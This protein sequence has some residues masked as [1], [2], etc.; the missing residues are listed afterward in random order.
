MPASLNNYVSCS[1]QL[2][3]NFYRLVR[4][5][6]RKALLMFRI[7]GWVVMISLLLKILPIERAFKIIAPQSDSSVT[8]IQ[9]YSPAQLA[10]MLDVILSINFC[11]FTPTCWKR[12]PVLFR[13]L[14]LSG[15][16]SRIMFGVRK[17]GSDG[18][19]GH[20]WLEVADQPI[21]EKSVARYTVTYSFPASLNRSS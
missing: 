4:R 11:F 2:S 14:S 19:A 18:L 20:A 13:Y 3:S 9:G 16:H 12:A 17:E 15:I 8:K 10:Q 21:C 5:E 7:A 6:P 1:R